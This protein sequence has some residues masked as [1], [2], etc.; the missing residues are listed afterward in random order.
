[1]RGTS[2]AR[3]ACCALGGISTVV[4]SVEPS[5]YADMRQGRDH[6]QETRV[7]DRAARLLGAVV[8]PPADERH[9]HERQLEAAQAERD[10]AGNSGRH[11]PTSPPQP[12]DGRRGSMPGFQFPAHTSAH[13]AFEQLRVIGEVRRRRCRRRRA[14]AAGRRTPSA[15]AS[16]T[17]SRV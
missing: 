9:R 14:S 16:R 5:R 8:R 13:H 12:A 6:E 1:M 10:Q 7:A 11:A 17:K 15:T 4:T 2:P 3:S